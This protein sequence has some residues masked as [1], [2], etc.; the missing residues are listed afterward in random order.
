MTYSQYLHAMLYYFVENDS[1]SVINKIKPILDDPLI[2]YYNFVQYNEKQ[3]I[4]NVFDRLFELYVQQHNNEY[5]KCLWTLIHTIPLVAKANNPFV[6]Y[7]Y[8]SFIINN[9]NC[10]HCILHYITTV[11]ELKDNQWYDNA[12]IFA[13]MIDLHNE[14]NL[15]R[16]KPAMTTEDAS[17]LYNEKIKN[18][19]FV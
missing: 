18:L 7:F 16:E 5:L 15:S 1:D 19:T 3:R 11:S 8:K 12:F 17:T 10:V 9:V 2:V 13:T 4:C 14:I 6:K